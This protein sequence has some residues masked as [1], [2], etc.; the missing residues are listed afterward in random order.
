VTVVDWR[1]AGL[2]LPSTVRAGRLLVLERRILT[3][4]LGALTQRDL[5]AVNGGLLAVLGLA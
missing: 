4:M 3:V 5:E 1:A 2:K